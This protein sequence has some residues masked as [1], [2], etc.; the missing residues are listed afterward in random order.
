MQLVNKYVFINVRT[1][2]IDAQIIAV[3]V[4][5]KSSERGAQINRGRA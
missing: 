5:G 3:G 1:R 4:Y 2:A